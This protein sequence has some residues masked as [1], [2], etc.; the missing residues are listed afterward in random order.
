V[1]RITGRALVD[2]DHQ[3]ERTHGETFYDANAE[4]YDAVSEPHWEA[5]GPALTWVLAPFADAREAVVDVGAGTGLG[6]V[7]LT[8]AA[9]WCSVLTVEPS[10]VLR[11]ALMARVVGDDD[12][13][14]RTTSLP[15]DLDGA[16]ASGVP[17]RLSAL[18]A[19]NMSRT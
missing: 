2:D 7:L 5:Y 16:L 3:E 13:S 19:S 11:V 8:R 6:T 14:A 17:E 10:P 1:V 4:F 15:T 18:V 12:L 9:P